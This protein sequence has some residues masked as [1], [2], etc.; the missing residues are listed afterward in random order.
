MSMPTGHQAMHRPQPT[1]PDVSNWSCQVDSLWVIHCRYRD[2]VVHR[3]EPPWSWE[4][5]TLKQDAQVRC[6]SV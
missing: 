4:W 1:H 5:S 3:I 6:C 2:R